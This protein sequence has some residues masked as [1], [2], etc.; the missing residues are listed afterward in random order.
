MFALTVLHR[1]HIGSL[2]TKAM[3]TSARG[4]ILALSAPLLDK[5]YRS[6]LARQGF[7]HISANRLRSGRHTIFG[8]GRRIRWIC[9]ARIE[10]LNVIVIPSSAHSISDEIA[11]RSAPST[12]FPIDFDGLA[13]GQCVSSSVSQQSCESFGPRKFLAELYRLSTRRT[14]FDSF[15]G[16]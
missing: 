16:S 4:N 10:C 3:P 1:T 9:S 13:I 12:K 11:T 8:S 15:A 5:M 6:R 14:A 7:R 2:S